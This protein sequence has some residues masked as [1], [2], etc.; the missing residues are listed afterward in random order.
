VTGF[1]N[2]GGQD[3][4]DF[5]ILENA[6]AALMEHYD[7][8]HIFVSRQDGDGT[9]YVSHGRGNYCARFGQIDLWMERQRN[10]QKGAES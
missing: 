9:F 8:V 2:T 5:Q 1:E 10:E 6:A 7:T 3:E 4:R